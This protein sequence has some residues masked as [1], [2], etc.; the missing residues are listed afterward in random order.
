MGKFDNC[1]LVSDMDGTLLNINHEISQEN[2]NA[3][4]YFINQ[5]GTFTVATGRMVDAVG[6]YSDRLPLN[7]PAVLHNGAKIYDYSTDKTIF[8]KFIEENR[9]YDIKRFLDSSPNVGLEIYC[10]EIVYILKPCSETKRFLTR[11]YNVVYQTPEYIWDKPWIK[12]L[13]IGNSK[14]ELDMYEPIY[15]TEYD[16]GYC[17]RSGPLYLDI[18]A[19]GVSKFLGAAE[20]MKQTH[21]QTLITIGDS[22]NDIDMLKHAD[23]SFAV[24][25][26]VNAAKKAALYQAPNH[27]QNAL[28]YA[29]SK[30]DSLL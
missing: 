11:N 1:L 16:T 3:I 18:V 25:N 22:E 2:L 12:L 19:G 24:D 15:R 29:I 10:D 23:I 5:G 7:A 4:N 8:E 21:K 14:D 6:A 20:V 30:L 27:N 9:K 26:A 17:V 13:V 28:S